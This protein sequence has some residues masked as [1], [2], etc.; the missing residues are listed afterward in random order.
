[1]GADLNRPGRLEATVQAMW[2]A[3]PDTGGSPVEVAHTAII[4]E[5]DSKLASYRAALEAG[6]DPQLVAGWI[7]EVQARRAS[8]VRRTEAVTGRTRLSLD[9]VR[10]LVSKMSDLKIV[11]ARAEPEPRA[12]VYRQLGL[13]LI[14]LHEQ[15]LVR[16]EIEINPNSWGYGLCPRGDSN[17]CSWESCRRQVFM[18][19]TIPMCCAESQRCGMPNDGSSCGP[20]S[21]D[22]GRPRL[23]VSRRTT[24][25][26]R[27]FASRPRC[28]ARPQ[29]TV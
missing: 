8:A 3:Q 16:A 21:A 23:V 9:E 25:A 26:A 13:K 12:E 15:A 5:C 20:L 6:A 22:S 18:C 4:A 17:T 7:T 19:W 29:A 24:A 10:E 27:A 11:L 2:S 14:Y 1:M 28:S